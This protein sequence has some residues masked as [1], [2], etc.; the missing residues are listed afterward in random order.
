MMLVAA[1]L[2][3]GMLQGAESASEPTFHAVA[4]RRGICTAG[5]PGEEAHPE[6]AWVWKDGTSPVRLEEKD[7]QASASEVAQRLALDSKPL[8]VIA[9]PLHKNGLLAV[10]AAPKRMW[11]EVPEPLLPR[12]PVSS[13]GTARIPSGEG[14]RLRVVGRDEGTWWMDVPVAAPRPLSLQRADTYRLKVTDERGSAMQASISLIATGTAP[15]VLAQLRTDVRGVAEI[16]GLPDR[17]ALAFVVS[18]PDHAPLAFAARVTQLPATLILRPGAIVSGRFLDQKKRPLSGVQV[19]AESWLGKGAAVFNRKSISDPQGM[20]KIEQVPQQKVVVAATHE[21][22]VP[23]RQELQVAKSR[24]DLGSV[25]LEPA[26]D[27]N[28]SV[29]DDRTGRPVAGVHIDAGFG[30]TAT[31]A[32]KGMAIVRDVA[33]NHP[34]TLTARAAGYL[35]REESVAPPFRK[36]PRI[37]MTRAF[38]VKGKFLSSAGLAVESASIRVNSGNTSRDVALSGGTFALDLPPD[39]SSTLEFRSP[40]TRDLSRSVSG[41]RGELRDLGLL[42]PPSGPEVRGHIVNEQGLPVAGASVWAPRAS[43]SGPLVAWVRGDVLRA[44][45]DDSGSFVLTGM[46]SEPLLL[47]IDATGYARAF[48]DVP[49]GIGVDNLDLGDVQLQEGGVLKVLAPPRGDDMTAAIALRSE[50]SEI[51]SLSASVREGSATFPHVPSGPVVVTLTRGRAT[52]C[53]KEVDVADGRVPLEVDCSA[54]GLHATGTV[55][56]GQRPADGGTLIWSA[57]APAVPIEGIILNR[58]TGLGARQQQ[59]FGGSSDVSVRVSESGQF[60]TDD[61][62]AGEWRVRWVSTDGMTT[63]PLPATIAPENAKSIVLQFAE[64]IV[65]GSVV[66]A[67]GHPSSHAAVREVST[68][69]AFALAGEDGTFALGGLLPGPH[70]L[71]AESGDLVSEVIAVE[72]K[73]GQSTDPMRLIVKARNRPEVSIRVIAAD[74]RPASGGFVFVET[75]DGIQVASIDPSSTATFSFQAEAPPAIRAAADAEG[76]WALGD[77]ISRDNLPD[78]LVLRLTQ[79]GSVAITTQGPAGAVSLVR[80]DGWN[81][82]SLLMRVGSRLTVAPSQPLRVEGLPAGEY[83]VS[84][85]AIQRAVTVKGG[86]VAVALFKR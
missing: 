19:A 36:E 55:L 8:H 58:Q 67:D 41:R 53:R 3:C 47:R 35:P 63:E 11:A 21:G 65:R 25:L 79:P 74:G 50:T 81:L 30:R 18:E 12:Y 48:R 78:P 10:L 57:P 76:M 44:E 51:D 26:V 54:D 62:R 15:V 14:L 1:F 52:I 33:A 17:E 27:L 49:A 42:H 64:G 32:S 29:V 9:R 84:I 82:S 4:C 31:S 2:W 60:E 16:E 28:L 68:G 73:S 59:A 43:S 39:E 24:E 80:S 83:S 61:L 86:E 22:F 66:D 23:F 45:A 71:R 75:K 46:E 56:I 69:G 6:F 34:L 13:E 40:S 85:G 77:W 38:Q 37:E 5:W 72:V 7:L 20:W 70:R